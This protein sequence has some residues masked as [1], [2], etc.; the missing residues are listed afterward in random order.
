MGGGA[1]SRGHPGI[2]AVLGIPTWWQEKAQRNNTGIPHGLGPSGGSSVITSE[3]SGPGN[4]SV[5]PLLPITYICTLK[6]TSN[7]ATSHKKKKT[8]TTTAASKEAAVERAYP[9]RTL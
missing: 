1:P 3:A 7:S 9:S 8:L 2:S 4:R 5:F 6:E